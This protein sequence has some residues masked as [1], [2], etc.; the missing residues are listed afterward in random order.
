M[1]NMEGS[2][3]L[4]AWLRLAAITVIVTA[5]SW[6]SP[7][8]AQVPARYYLKGL[9]GVDAVPLIIES[10]SGNTNPFDPAH[11][12]SS[13]ASINAT[14]AMAGFGR[15]FSL[16]DR[17][18]MLAVLVPMG[19]IS[20]DVY[21]GGNLVSESTGGYGDPMIECAINI[22][23]PKAQESLPDVLRY[24]PGFSVD[25]LGDLAV[26]V[27]EYNNSQSLNI[28]QNRWYGRLGA[29][30]TW[31]IGPWVPGRRT[32]LEL[33]PAVWIFGTNSDYVGKTLEADPLFQLDGHLTHDLADDLWGALDFAWYVG[34]QASVDGVKGEQLNNFAVGPTLNYTINDNLSLAFMYKSTI[35]D[36]NPSDLR[37]DGFKICF[38]YGW[39]P[40]IQGMKR[41]KEE[42]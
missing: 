14:L 23:G 16:F 27:G 31:Q 33:L 1:K 18:G 39:H 11:V 3:D 30:V 2:I 10:I 32:T 35:N 34:G 41:I 17:G 20:G 22:L 25:L 19:T 5:A 21:Y 24:E 40:I 12:V 37:M 29:P 26:P 36:K 9:S 15:M 8:T 4:K 6:W 7:A 13:G 28:G 42:G 38:V